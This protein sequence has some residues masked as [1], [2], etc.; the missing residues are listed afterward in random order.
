KRW[1]FD[2][3]AQTAVGLLLADTTAADPHPTIAVA[4]VAESAEEFEQQ[5]SLSGIQLA[6]SALGLRSEVP[7]L[8]NQR[9]ADVLVKLRTTGPFPLGGGSWRCF[10]VQGDFNET[11][12]R[13][14]WEGQREGWP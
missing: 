14:L 10:P 11:T 1:A 9:V 2:I 13:A 8:S 3:H 6:R 4:G 7:L 12:D 5:I